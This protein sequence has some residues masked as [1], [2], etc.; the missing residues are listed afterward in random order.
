MKEKFT[1][2]AA[3]GSYDV[4]NKLRTALKHLNVPVEIKDDGCKQEQPR[5]EIVV[6]TPDF[7]PEACE[8]EQPLVK[9]RVR[10]E[11][12]DNELD[13]IEKFIKVMQGAPRSTLT[14]EAY[15]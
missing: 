10:F 8:A 3:E 2:Q 11:R 14:Y 6:E 5:W 12:K 13:M 4:L 15:K 7:E 9:K 1:I